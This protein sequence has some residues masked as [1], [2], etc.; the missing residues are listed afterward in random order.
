M[1]HCFN[2]HFYKDKLVWTGFYVLICYLFLHFVLIAYWYSLFFFWFLKFSC[3][4]KKTVSLIIMQWLQIYFV[5][6]YLSIYVIYKYCIVRTWLWIYFCFWFLCHD[7]SLFY[8]HIVYYSIYQGYRVLLIQSVIK[9]TEC[10]KLR[11]DTET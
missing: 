1:F 5:V 11:S 10:S 7:L 2:T 3:T 9:Y 6:C 4:W 8:M